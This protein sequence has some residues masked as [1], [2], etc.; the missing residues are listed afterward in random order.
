[1]GASS[2][3]GGSVAEPEPTWVGDEEF[4]GFRGPYAAGPPPA[5]LAV[6]PPRL[7]R[8]GPAELRRLLRVAVVIT[9][10][11]AGALARWAARRDRRAL[12][13]VLSDGLVDSFTALGPMFVKF[14]QLMASSPSVFPAPLADTALRCIREVAPF[15]GPTARAI[16]EAD[17][18]RPPSELFAHFD[19]RP[20]AAASVAQVHGCV[21]PD[22]RQAVVKIQRPDI[23]VTMTKDLRVMARLARRLERHSGLARDANLTGAVEDLHAVTFS[24]LNSALEAHRQARFRAGIVAFGDNAA[25]TA[26]EVYW[27]YCGPHVICMERLFGVPLDDFDA[28]RRRSG[29]GAMLLRRSVK[30]WMEACMVHG[31]FHGDVHA[32]NIWVLDDGRAAYL[33]FGIMGEVADDWKELMRDVFATSTIDNDFTRVAR[34]F[35]RV[36]A[37]PDDAGTDEDIAARMELVFTPML[38]AGLSEVSMGALLASIIRTIGQFSAGAGTPRELHLII[39]QLLYIE[40]YAHEL[41][42]QW[43]MFRDLYIVRN[44]FPE[45]VAAKAAAVGEVF[46]D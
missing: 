19:D 24:E 15:D 32:G 42:P 38:D 2:E 36:G 4:D 34:A 13:V 10:H 22:G 17:L 23:R 20:L 21:L 35:K 30:V 45:A 46:P 25:V 14:G 9:A 27:E 12:A 41:A 28:V 40:R 26:P 29:E 31:L 18:G 3:R 6:D 39:K 44:V 7:D 33:D 5:A 43:A 8:F 1:M 37:F 11:L 16:I